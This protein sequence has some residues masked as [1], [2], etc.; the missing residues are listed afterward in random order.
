M[1]GFPD[2]FSDLPDYI[3]K[4]TQEIWEDRRFTY[5]HSCY[6]PDIIMRSTGGLIRGNDGV[7]DDTMATLAETPDKQ[8]YGED[9]IW[10]GSDE[11]GFLSSH[12]IF[13]TGTHTGHGVFGPPTG[14]RFAVRAIADCAARD[15]VIYDEWLTRDESGVALQFGLDPADLARNQ[16]AAEGGPDS[17]RRPFTPKDDIAGPYTARGNDNEW[18][19][20]LAAT[21]TA[22]MDKDISTIRRDYDRAAHIAH[23][24]NR[25]GLSWAFAETEWM[26]LRSAFPSARFSIDHCIGRADPGQPNRA[27]VRWSLTGRHD[28]H[29]AFGNPTGALVHVMGFTHAEFGPWGLRREYTLFDEVAIWKQIHLHTGNAHADTRS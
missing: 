13:T 7:I 3:L 15:G 19:Q 27:A 26:Q 1:K 29:G 23:P 8:L 17:A 12:R 2:R 9:V 18:G 20:S 4:I 14:K 25:N 6:A 28:G 21:L 24:G 10:S 5:L 16:I 22:I 11:E